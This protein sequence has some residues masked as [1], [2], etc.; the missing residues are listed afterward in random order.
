MPFIG[1]FALYFL[2]TV[3]AQT[4][5]P[6]TT[7]CALKSN[8]SCD[9]CLQNVTC[10]WCRT[11]QQCIDYPVRTVLPSHSL[12]PLPEARW[13]L[14]WMNFQTLI[15]T[16][17]VIAGMIIISIL[18][19]CFCCCKCERVGNKKEDAKVERQASARKG[20]QQERKTEMRMR[21]DEIRQKY[22]LAKETPY[23]RFEDS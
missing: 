1:F 3:E 22:G 20:R 12:C 9:E 14:C 10:L 18:V 21:H 2:M 23:S 16:M 8:T 6:S 19:C 17:S 5:T 4:P 13:G 15:I 7:T 11:T